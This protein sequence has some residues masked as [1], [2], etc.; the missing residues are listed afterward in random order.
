MIEFYW[1][2]IKDSR[3][4]A[5]PLTKLLRKN[6]R[7]EWGTDHDKAFKFLSSWFIDTPILKIPHSEQPFTIFTEASQYVTDAVFMQTHG[8]KLHLIAFCQ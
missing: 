7:F 5:L 3:K 1:S 6:V 2:F 4:V 8:F